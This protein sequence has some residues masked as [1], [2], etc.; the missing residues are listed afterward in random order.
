MSILLAG[1][2][3]HEAAAIEIMVGM[4]WRDESCIILKRALSLSVP[5][6]GAVAR[7]CRCCVLDLFGLG[8]R[9]YS[10]EREQ[11]LLRFLNG[12]SAVLLAWGDGGGWLE[13][14][15]PLAK[16]QQLRWLTMPYS[17]AALRESLKAVLPPQQ[18]GA[19]PRTSSTRIRPEAA[20]PQADGEASPEPS[21]VT[22]PS[23]PSWRDTLQPAEERA[24]A[25]A[26]KSV[27]SRR[28]PA[29][30]AAPADA[31]GHVEAQHSA[32]PPETLAPI[33]L[34][35]G[36]VTL[37]TGAMNALLQVFPMLQQVPLMR[38]T[39]EIVSR[40]GAQLLRIA[41]DVAFVLD[42]RQGWMVSGLSIPALLKMLHTPQLLEGVEVEPLP[43]EQIEETVRQ[44]FDGRFH[45]AQRPIDVIMWELAY[46]ALQDLPLANHGDFRFQLM[47]F[48]NF[49]LFNGVGPIDV[50]L[51]AICVRMP[52]TLAELKRAFPHHEQ[53]VLR[54]AAVS[55]VS[56]LAALLPATP[57]A[58]G[59]AG[60]SAA[61]APS[62]PSAAARARPQAAA[63]RRGFFKSLLDKLF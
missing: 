42:L 9:K 26:R 44:R 14:S 24:A 45:R 34:A 56:G 33:Q 30:A 46:D 52:Q 21:A 37:R 5:A 47:R 36:A 11:E 1:L 41:N 35:E 15:L 23:T 4:Q 25:P 6:Q 53:D 18:A 58:L 16:G 19:A 10:P 8:M 61:P 39:R 59:A 57:R 17:S 63:V 32:F 38:L 43:D 54:F 7:S 29:P 22:A 27:A 60:S 3:D 2:T 50:Q 55:L 48:P 62:T 20:A 13:A 28:A 31:A 12:R 51:A 49:T 40:E